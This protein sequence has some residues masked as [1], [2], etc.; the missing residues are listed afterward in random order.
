M[1]GPL[2]VEGRAVSWRRDGP[3]DG[4]PLVLLAHGAGAAYTSPFMQAVAAGLAARELAVLRF[5]FPYMERNV[6]EGRRG[7]P[8]RPPILLATWRAV[9]DA[10]RGLAGDATPLVLAGKSMGGR[11]ASMLLAE[12][13]PAGVRAGLY[14]GYPLSPAGRADVVRADHLAAVQVPQLFLSGSRDPLCNLARLRAVLEPIGARAQ[15]HVVEGGDHSLATSRKDPLAGSDAWLD[16]AAQFVRK[17][18]RQE[19]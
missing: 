15:L 19:G 3:L 4:R 12:A 1:T 7:A 14:F 16:V 10:A 6:R 2:R 17:V 13:T 5:H 11:I 8:D 9:I 18:A